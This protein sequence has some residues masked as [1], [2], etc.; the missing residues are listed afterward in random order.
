LRDYGNALSPFNA[1]LL[2]QGLETLSLRVQRHVDNTLAI[3]KWLREQTWVTKV[4]YPGLED[5]EYHQKAKKYLKNGFGGVLTFNVKGGQEAAEK[6]VNNVELI[7]HLANVGDA[8]SLIIHSWST[9]HEQLPEK[10]RLAS[11]VEPDAIRLSVGIEHVDDIK[12]DLV[13]AY[14]SI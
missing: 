1:F 11:G 7:S 4:T 13:R 10:E 5:N 8:R 2:I 12:D 6:L 3:A 9:T 14:N